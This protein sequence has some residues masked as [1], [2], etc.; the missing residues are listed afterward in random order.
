MKTVFD[1]HDYRDFLRD[2][3]EAHKSSSP[4]IGLKVFAERLGIGNSNLKMILTKKRKLSL[5][6]FM[7]ISWA[8]KLSKQEHSYLETLVLRDGLQ[9]KKDRTFYSSRGKNIK[10]SAHLDV[11]VMSQKSVLVDELTLPIIVYLSENS[12]DPIND[13]EQ[14]GRI[15]SNAFKIPEKRTLQILS[16]IANEKDLVISSE[17]GPI[18]FAFSQIANKASQKEYL[19]KWLKRSS[20]EVEKRFDDQ[21]TFFTSSTVAIPEHL[22]PA[23]KSDLKNVLEKYMSITTE[24]ST[25]QQIVQT[26]IQMF[27]LI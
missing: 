13:L 3:Y 1:Y 9:E 17:E 26:N 25:H 10:K 16:A 15:V 18:H 14:C 2:Q 12:F 5:K 6:H 23:L 11:K 8:L 21:M 27:G 7:K 24:K 4:N 22:I 20:E 19:Q